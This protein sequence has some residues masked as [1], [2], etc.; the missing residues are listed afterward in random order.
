MF[1]SIQLIGFILV[2]F[3]TLISTFEVIRG[4]LLIF[5]LIA[6]YQ[7]NKYVYMKHYDNQEETAEGVI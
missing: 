5:S 6:L 1:A 7:M 3:I 4:A 2:Y